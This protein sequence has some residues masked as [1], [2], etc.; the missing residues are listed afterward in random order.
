MEDSIKRIRA[1]AKSLNDQDFILEQILSKIKDRR[2]LPGLPG[3]SGTDGDKGNTGEKGDQGPSGSIGPQGPEGPPG[4]SGSIVYEKVSQP[5]PHAKDIVVDTSKFGRNLTKYDD[6]VQKALETLDNL[7]PGIVSGGLGAV[8]PRGSQGQM[9]LRGF[10]GPPGPA[11]GDYD[12]QRLRLEAGWNQAY[13][14]GYAEMTYSGD[15][16]TNV[17]IWNT[18][19]KVNKLF[20]KIISYSGDNVSSTVMTDETTS[21]V[22]TKTLAYSGSNVISVTST[23]T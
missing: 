8:G 7:Y 3:L 22:L 16:I 19:S 13:D 17:D 15:N 11:G 14:T 12:E 21:A 23:V 1:F 20:S 9:G 2:G 6:T 5:I 18:A 10:T 4:P